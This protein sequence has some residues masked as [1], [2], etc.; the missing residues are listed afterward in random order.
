MSVPDQN[1][2]A[3]TARFIDKDWSMT[4]DH[5]LVLFI[6]NVLTASLNPILSVKA[7]KQLHAASQVPSVA[8]DV[9]TM[10]DKHV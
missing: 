1:N 7:Y 4:N 2:L 10:S 9:H 5:H 3:L 6:L 8:A